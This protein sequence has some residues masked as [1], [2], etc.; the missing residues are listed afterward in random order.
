MLLA[1]AE[2]ARRPR[3][4]R[5]DV[6]GFPVIDLDTMSD[7]KLA[8]LHEAAHRSATEVTYGMLLSHTYLVCRAAG[9]L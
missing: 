3:L 2:F 7:A 9:L 4:R 8:Q 1:L 5:E 6:P